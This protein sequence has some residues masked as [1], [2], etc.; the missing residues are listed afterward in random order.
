[1]SG[2]LSTL[3][4]FFLFPTHKQH[5]KKLKNITIFTVNNLNTLTKMKPKFKRNRLCSGVHYEESKRA[6]IQFLQELHERNSGYLLSIQLVHRVPS[7]LEQF[8]M[9]LKIQIEQYKK[10]R[11]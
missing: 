2:L 8:E 3:H 7:A 4:S 9:N 5:L 11:R 1:M 10:N 6:H